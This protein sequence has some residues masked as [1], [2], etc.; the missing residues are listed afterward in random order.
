MRSQAF[1]DEW[2]SVGTAACAAAAAQCAE[3]QIEFARDINQVRARVIESVGVSVH[4]AAK[5]YLHSRLNK[6]CA[7][8]SIF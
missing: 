6:R 3:R 7:L 5:V 8:S 1:I 2:E 4:S